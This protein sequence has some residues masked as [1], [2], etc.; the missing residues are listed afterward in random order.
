M[1]K[2]SDLLDQEGFMLGDVVRRVFFTVGFTP[3]PGLIRKIER[4]LLDYYTI[5]MKSLY[6]NLLSFQGVS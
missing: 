4:S 5:F 6:L 3:S 1:I 2:Y